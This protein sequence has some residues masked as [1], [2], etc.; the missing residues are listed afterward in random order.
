MTARVITATRALAW[1]A[2]LLWFGGAIAQE[3]SAG[4]VSNLSGPLF[5]VKADGTRRVLSMQSLVFPGDT[6]ITEAKTYARLRFTDN[7]EVTLRPESQF[8][9]ETYHYDVAA[10]DK[11][12]LAYRLLKGALR[13]VT[14]LIGKRG[15]V[16]AYQLNT[17]TATI[18]VRGTSFGVIVCTPGTCGSLSPGTYVNVIDGRV[19]IAPPPVVPVIPTPT[20]FAPPGVPPT[21]PPAAPPPA[22]A[23]APMVLSA[24]Q[25]GYVPPAG[26]P[27]QLPGDPGLGRTFTPPPT[28]IQRPDAAPPS[29]SGGTGTK[30]ATA[31]TAQSG[32]DCEVR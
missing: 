18:G 14:G 12:N 26:P 6:L 9:V 10:P 7:G 2:A 4:Y 23:P 24:G 11:D 1:L 25:F 13:T 27:V 28:F 29:Q 31:T 22:P 20:P 8:R 3:T 19:A 17:A 32:G 21:A 16:D 30:P 5:A 15:S